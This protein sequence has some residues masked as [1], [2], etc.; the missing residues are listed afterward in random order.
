M[1]C[2]TI[3]I[4]YNILFDL[5]NKINH[6]KQFSFLTNLQIDLLFKTKATE[7]LRNFEHLSPP[8]KFC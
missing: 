7:Y 8:Y 6:S 3:N 2:K 5:L 4:L 1:Y